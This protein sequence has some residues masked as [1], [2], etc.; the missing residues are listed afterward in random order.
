MIN[1]GFRISGFLSL[2]R[3]NPATER[4]KVA[5]EC[6]EMGTRPLRRGNSPY[7]F[8]TFFLFLFPCF[9]FFFLPDHALILVGQQS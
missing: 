4:N 9:L 6:V 5:R 8:F 1:L 3:A 7:L 2:E